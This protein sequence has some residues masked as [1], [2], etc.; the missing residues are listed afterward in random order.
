LGLNKRKEEKRRVKTK[1][2]RKEEKRKKKNKEKKK[3][4]KKRERAQQKKKVG[5]IKGKNSKIQKMDVLSVI[6]I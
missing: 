5:T 2:E 4:E 6:F 3:N 1:K